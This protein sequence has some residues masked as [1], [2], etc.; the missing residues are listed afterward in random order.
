VRIAIFL[1]FY[2]FPA[3]L[4][5]LQS[6]LPDYHVRVFNESV[7]IKNYVIKSIS[8][9]K[10]GF[11]WILYHDGAQR[12]D[13]RR[14]WNFKIAEPNY[15]LCDKKN[16]IWVS[17]NKQHYKY[18][19]DR[20]GFLPVE[21]DKKNDPFG[22]VFQLADQHLYLQR[23]NGFYRLN[24]A[25]NKFELLSLPFAQLQPIDVTQFDS[26]E[27]TIFFR[28]RD[29]IYSYNFSSRLIRSLP[30][31]NLYKFQA[32]NDERLMVSQWNYVSWWYN[33]R[34][35][36]MKKID[37]RSYFPNEADTF[38]NIRRFIPL[39]GARYLASSHLGLLEYDNVADSFRQLQ[40]YYEGHPLN[41]YPSAVVY[42][43]DQQNI[44]MTYEGGITY[45][46]ISQS[47][48]GL[49]RNTANNRQ[50]D[51]SDNVRNLTEDEN[52]NIWFVT[53]NGFAYW[54]L[55]SGNIRAYPLPGDK[56]KIHL[57]P[58]IRGLAFDGQYVI[59]GPTDFGPWLYDVTKHN[60]LRLSYGQ[61]SASIKTKKLLEGEFIN[62]IYRL[63]DGNYVIS[64]KSGLYLLNGK[65][66]RARLIDFGKE[67]ERNI[68]CYED[69]RNRKWIRTAGNLYCLDSSF[70]FL[71]KFP[72]PLGSNSAASFI[73]LSDQHF[74]AGAKGL[75][76]LNLDNKEP[77]LQKIDPYFDMI[78]IAFIFRDKRNRLWMGTDN[79]LVLYDPQSQEKRVFDYTDNV[80]G[81][82]Y[83]NQGFYLS[84]K[85]V[86]YIAGT[87]GINFFTPE[88]IEMRTEP[89]HASIINMVINGDDSS[90]QMHR[91]PAS[92]SYNKN[93]MRFD[94]VAPYFH[95]PGLVQYKYSLGDHQWNEVG[96]NTSIYFTSLSPGTYEFKVAA[97]INGRDWFESVPIHFSISPPFWNTWWFALSSVLVIA[98][99]LYVLYKYRISQIMKLQMVRNR[100]SAEL[101]DDIGTKLTNINILST[102]TNQ[103]MQDTEKAKQ[104][105]KRISNE[106]Q[107]S[108]EALDDIVWNINTKNDTLEEIIPR[109]RRYATEVLNGKM[110]RFNIQV[111]E[112]IQHT[113]LSMEKRHDVYLLFKEMVNNIHKHANARQVLIEI[114]MR[115]SFFCLHV[116]DDGRGFDID[117]PSG[118][119]GLF[120]MK[121]RAERW[122]GKLTIESGFE[123]GTDIRVVLPLKKI[124][125]NGV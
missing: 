74:L 115:D 60:Y 14:V 108:S 99:L 72:Q 109:M 9:D 124:H 106:V 67:G 120:N 19:N 79:G 37:M 98:Y 65:T 41:S 59:L 6:Q 47:G 29:S 83:Y 51:W 69:S 81:Y 40:L 102:L 42:K 26:H 3:F 45:F 100:I 15:I 105:L 30:T 110:L 121:M 11:L 34:E 84:R 76:A 114:E 52:G 116:N 16:T 122:K 24:E 123:K 111:P 80:Q 32:I 85:G 61:D 5:R 64:G 22:A 25:N 78:T 33:F 50:W 31:T 66:Y 97:S 119:N 58:S 27:Q 13:G 90:Y 112:N 55:H 8:R 62:Q 94:F 82:G 1:L 49:I 54:D 87:H 39:G 10:N 12:F 88:S 23:R 101:H 91:L 46:N 18:S 113:K 4:S 48:I 17:S 28:V 77:S 93:S 96:N 103:A 53:I 117:V 21:V 104:L 35:G 70:H 56:K 57:Y 20:D 2:L 89:L 63:R 38:L 92:F 75:Y 125:S 107:T 71:Y 7:G 36:K 73:E 118:R 43:D 44:W 68:F 95:N 86:L